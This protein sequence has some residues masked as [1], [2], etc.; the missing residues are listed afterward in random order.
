MPITNPPHLP[1]S[2]QTIS[3]PQPQPQNSRDLPHHY[4]QHSTDLPHH[5]SE[6]A[7]DLPNH[8]FDALQTDHHDPFNLLAPVSP[9][10]LIEVNPD[11]LITFQTP[12]PEDSPYPPPLSSSTDWFDVFHSAHYD[13]QASSS[14]P[15]LIEARNP[16]D[17]LTFQAPL[18]EDPPYPLPLSYSRDLPPYCF[19]ALHADHYDPLV[20]SSQSHLIELRN[21]NPFLTFQTPLTDAPP[22]P[23][24]LPSSTDLPPHCFD[25]FHDGFHSAHYDPPATSSQTPLMK[26]T[27]PDTFLTFQTPFSEGSSYLPP[28]SNSID[29]PLHCFDAFHTDTNHRNTDNPQ[30]SSSDLIESR[31][32]NTPSSPQT[33]SS[34]SSLEPLPL[35]CE[36]DHEAFYKSLKKTTEISSIYLINPYRNRS[37]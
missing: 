33:P 26:A 17:Y 24:L 9:S 29:L 23:P 22:Y 10:H 25:A 5:F 20:S 36:K 19:D 6:N 1:S 32:P 13:P 7:R 21:P 27:Y 37:Y 14:Q 11:D 3:K 18:P 31:G 8:C 4:P 34:E 16:D 28:L 2:Y 30:A 15:P 12:F 35:P